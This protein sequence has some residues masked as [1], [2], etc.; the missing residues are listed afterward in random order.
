MVPCQKL[1]QSPSTVITPARVNIPCSTIFLVPP[2]P[3]QLIRCRLDTAQAWAALSSHRITA[4][5]RKS[6]L[7]PLVLGI[8]CGWGETG[9]SL[10]AGGEAGSRAEALLSCSSYLEGR[11][12]SSLALLWGDL[13]LWSLPPAPPGCCSHKAPQQHIATPQST[14]LTKQSP[15]PLPCPPRGGEADVRGLYSPHGSPGFWSLALPAPCSWEGQ[16]WTDT[17]QMR[18]GGRQLAALLRLLMVPVPGHSCPLPLQCAHESPLPAYHSPTS[19]PEL[20]R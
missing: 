13:P 11:G 1:D 18:R 15:A 14:A 10:R 8:R 7:S 9:A 2:Q 6:P 5:L 3:A 4:V 19:T 12:G 20:H 17:A 16:A